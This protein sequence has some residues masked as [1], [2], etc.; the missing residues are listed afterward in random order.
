MTIDL[1]LTDA[2]T[3]APVR[4][5][6]TRLVIAGFTGR[7]AAAVAAHIEE[8]RQIGVPVPE[9]TPAFYELPADLLTTEDSVEV[10]GTFTS[11][12]V[13]PA[14]LIDEEQR[15]LTVGS[16][17]TDRELEASSIVQS[18]RVCPKPIA[19]RLVPF[20]DADVWDDISLASTAD[21]QPYQSGSLAQLLPFDAVSSAARDAGLV[22]GPGDV[23]FLGT[24]PT[25][26]ELR[27]AARFHASMR[28]EHHQLELAYDITCPTS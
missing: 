8:L 11:G 10:S 13:E 28:T 7:D 14:V 15:W 12:E 24:V 18:K 25:L 5:A 6:A 9:V 3:E 4:F 20:P 16:D 22:L 19:S 23:I 21:G 26:G 2:S 1:H 17:H 27:A